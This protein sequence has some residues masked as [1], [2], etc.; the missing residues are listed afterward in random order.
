MA[1]VTMSV[2]PVVADVLRHELM[3]GPFIRAAEAAV[4]VA[5]DADAL[6]VPE[7]CRGLQEAA[8][9]LEQLGWEPTT[10]TVEFTADAD[11]VREQL[12]DALSSA[13][14][15]IADYG[16]GGDVAKEGLSEREVITQEADKIYQ[17][18][19]LLHQISDAEVP[20]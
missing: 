9:L 18:V 2:E 14:E 13:G 1:T 10:K 16:R 15:R 8:E 3:L 20:A 5:N 19:G 12:L 17:L 11:L 4:E 7:A 6:R